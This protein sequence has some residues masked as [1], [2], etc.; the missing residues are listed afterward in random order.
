MK[1]LINNV[2][3]INKMYKVFGIE[4]IAVLNENRWSGNYNNPTLNVAETQFITQLNT[5]EQP[6]EDETFL[7]HSEASALMR[8]VEWKSEEII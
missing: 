7:N 1:T 3:K 6:L 2:L 8:T 5:G 4:N